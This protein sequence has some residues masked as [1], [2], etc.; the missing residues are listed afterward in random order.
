ME[1]PKSVAEMIERY[2]SEFYEPIGRLVMQ[3]GM[4]EFHMDHWLTALAEYK[5]S[6]DRATLGQVRNFSTKITMY[7]QFIA[8][9]TTERRDLVERDRLV[10]AMR[11]LNTFRNRVIHGPWNGYLVEKK[12]WQKLSFNPQNFTNHVF[13]VTADE[14]RA[15]AN[16][17]AKIQVEASHFAFGFLAP[18]NA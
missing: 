9:R 4:L 7:G 8:Y 5:Q 15:A 3:F 10:K 16:D 17:V 2:D 13:E 14:I 18:K 1:H 12:A 11:E 6:Y